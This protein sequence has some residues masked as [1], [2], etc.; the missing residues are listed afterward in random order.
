MQDCS[1]AFSIIVLTKDSRDFIRPCLDSLFSQEYDDFETIVVD[2]GSK[3]STVNLIKDNYRGIAMIENFKNLGASRARN[4][5]LSVSRGKW[6]L[7]LDCDVALE[8]DFLSRASSLIE[9]MP[10]EM[11]ILQPKILYPGAAT[12]YSCGIYLSW[13]RRF[14]DIGRGR[15]DTGSY[16]KQKK[17]F[18]ACSAAGFYRRAMLD[19]IKEET[20]YFDERFFFLV[21]DVDLA[22]RARRKGWKAF[23]IPGL[24]CYHHGN[25]SS[26]DARLRQR[27]CYRNR[28]LMI[29]KNEGLGRYAR[30]ILPLLFYDLPR[31]LMGTLPKGAPLSTKN[32]EIYEFLRQAER[33]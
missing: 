18:G 14:Y 5:A 21:E 19:D 28:F 25:S 15:R 11:G 20:G 22:W 23:F 7:T 24:R 9:D 29:A 10:P 13:M 26:T 4:Q 27:L 1:K 32:A 6:I 31:Y 3:D 30:R 8:K 12:L 17:V 16:D 2:N 33:Q